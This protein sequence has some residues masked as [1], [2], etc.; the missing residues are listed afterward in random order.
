FNLPKLRAAATPPAYI[1]ELAAQQFPRD[2][3]LLA[4]LE[5]YIPEP[6]SLVAA[7]VSER[8]FYNQLASYWTQNMAQFA[9]FDPNAF[10]DELD[11]TIV[12]PLATS[13]GLFDRF[14]YLTR[15]ATLIS[16]EEMTKDPIFLFNR[17]LGDVPVLHQ[18]DATY[19]CGSMLYSHCDAPVRLR[20]PDGRT[21][22][23]A[24]LAPTTPTTTTCYGMPTGGYARGDIDALPSLQAAWQRAESGPGNMVIDK[25]PV[26]DKGVGEHNSGLQSGCGCS[27]GGSGA[28]GAWAIAALAAWLTLKGR[29]RR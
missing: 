24:P 15:L 11:S 9:P 25:N 4:L 1:A 6:A 14:P 2:A 7:G 17:D 3:K 22:R 5:K 18:A 29:R 13:Q 23:L 16:P 10:T 20:L 12:T 21:L 8:T 28:G 19:E 27:H 26:I